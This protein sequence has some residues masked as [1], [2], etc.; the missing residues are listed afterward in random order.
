MAESRWVRIG[1]RVA[2]VAVLAFL[3]IPLIIL[4]VYAFKPSRLQA[5]SKNDSV[6]CS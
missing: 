5:A 6:S 3:Y 4:I 1:L 2:T